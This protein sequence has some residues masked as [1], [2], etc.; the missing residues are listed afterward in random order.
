MAWHRC[1]FDVRPIEGLDF[2]QRTPPFP[3]TFTGTSLSKPRAAHHDRDAR[4]H[5]MKVLAELWYGVP[6]YGARREQVG[7][8]VGDS[9]AGR[10]GE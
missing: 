1:V 10:S 8:A 3:M 6:C 9:S 7:A 4:A 5:H 2:N